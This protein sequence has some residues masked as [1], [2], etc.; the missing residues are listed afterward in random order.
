M[1]QASKLFSIYE[2]NS[3]QLSVLFLPILLS[4]ELQP[5]VRYPHDT[6]Q[7]R[8]T[9]H[10]DPWSRNPDGN[11]TAGLST[12]IK[13]AHFVEERRPDE[14]PHDCIQNIERRSQILVY[15]CSDRQLCFP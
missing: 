10:N 2:M 3:I 15:F 12:Q 6:D 8:T 1:I 7:D 5:Q 11:N 4:K 13:R 14:S 9:D